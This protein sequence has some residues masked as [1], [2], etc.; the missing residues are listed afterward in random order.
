MTDVAAPTMPLNCR[1]AV[2][3]LV[4]DTLGPGVGVM[5]VL[6]VGATFGATR[7]DPDS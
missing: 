3:P 5:F 2:A 7:R 4:G 1:T 6:V